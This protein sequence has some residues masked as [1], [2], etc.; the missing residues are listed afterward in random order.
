MW[1]PISAPLK[2]PFRMVAEILCVKHLTTHISTDPHFWP[3]RGQI[4][5]F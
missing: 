1:F 5:R 3:V 2:P 4:R